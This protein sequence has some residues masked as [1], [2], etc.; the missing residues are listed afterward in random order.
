VNRNISEGATLS[1]PNAGGRYLSA[2][3][4]DQDHFIN[5]LLH[6]P[7]DYDLTIREFDTPWEMIGVRIPV[8]PG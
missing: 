4:V 7:G 3:V 6:E 8:D 1:L 2:M 5:R